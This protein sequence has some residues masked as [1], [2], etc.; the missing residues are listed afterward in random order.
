MRLDNRVIIVTG[1]GLGLGK[2]YCERLAQEGASIVVADINA[3]AAE[4]VAA[5]LRAAEGEAIAVPTD[6]TSQ[7][8]TEAM[9]RATLERFGHV[10]A[11]VNN[12]GMY[13]RPAVT[14]GPFEEIA[15]EEWDRVMSVNLR[16]TFLCARAV[17]PHMKQQ[18]SGKIVNVSSSTVFSGTPRFAHYV[19]SKAGVIG[20]TR[21]LAKELGEWN[22][23]V[24]AIAPGLTMSLE[25]ESA[26]MMDYHQTRAGQRAIKR[27]EKPDDLVGTVAFLCS[28]DSDFMSGQTL[29][30]DGGLSL[31]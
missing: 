5:E 6:V 14:R 3:D 17:V 2:A 30:V 15:V 9:V 8:A 28:P 20:F 25:E 19:T 16:G 24:N 7:D 31:H 26:E 12:A 4:S 1:G 27:L 22:I 29:V 18:R 10:D 13:Q 21:V 23:T 11:L